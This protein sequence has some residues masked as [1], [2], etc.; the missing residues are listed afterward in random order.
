M[1]RQIKNKAEVRAMIRA[2]PEKLPA[3]KG[4][5]FGDVC[6]HA[7]DVRRLQLERLEDGGRAA[8]PAAEALAPKIRALQAQFNIAEESPRG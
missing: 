3:C 1:S 2:E 4:C 7:P 6:W 5:C 8:R